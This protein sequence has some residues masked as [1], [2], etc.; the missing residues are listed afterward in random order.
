[1][2][3]LEVSDFHFDIRDGNAYELSMH[4]PR[5]FCRFYPAL[6]LLCFWPLL[7][8]G[9][10]FRVA[11]Y[12]VENYLD[13]GTRT[14]RAKP[15]E[16]KAK[17]RETILALKPDVIVLQE[18]GSLAALQ[19][20]RASLKEEGLEFPF[21]EHVTGFDT[22]IHLAI[23]SR[24]PFTARRP[25]TNDNFLLNG[26]RFSVSRGFA[27]ADI[28]VNTN[29]SFTLIAAHLKSKRP[30]PQADENE[31]R[32]EEAKVLREKIEA[33]LNKNPEANLIVLGD[34]NDTKDAPSIKTV[35]G[36][37][38]QKLVDTRPAERTGDERNSAGRNITWTHFYAAQDIYSRLDY[39]LLSPGMAREW[40]PTGTY[41]L[42]MPDWGLGSDHRPLVA[43]F[44][45]EE[46]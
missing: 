7:A 8:P 36:R 34:L 33:C 46:K 13:A 21:W 18:M 23:L 27:E 16:A 43:T 4:L 1:M 3:D 25:H 9:E 26:R 35:I 22:N 31:L 39:I 45:A 24:F 19:E 15:P 17:V 41:I 40:S 37:G 20:L 14:R 44:E 12:N 6:A 32:Q 28:Q 30:I 2:Q 29:Y 38:K 10:T 42:S 11:T 5:C